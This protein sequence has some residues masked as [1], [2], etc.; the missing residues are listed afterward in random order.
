MERK[1]P[2]HTVKPVQISTFIH[3]IH[4]AISKIKRNKIQIDFETFLHNS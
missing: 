2:Q 1:N 3:K 4:E